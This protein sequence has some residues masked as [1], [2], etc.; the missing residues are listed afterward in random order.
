MC[1]FLKLWRNTV[2]R[3]FK[4]PWLNGQVPGHLTQWFLTPKPYHRLCKRNLPCGWRFFCKFN[5]RKLGIVNNHWLIPV[6]YMVLVS[7][8][9]HHFEND[10]HWPSKQSTTWQS[11]ND[12]FDLIDNFSPSYS[13]IQSWYWSWRE[14]MTNIIMR[15]DVKTASTKVD[16]TL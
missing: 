1:I 13:F 8:V 16:R 12:H 7:M 15:N 14:R 4:K 6:I 10:Y 3:S 5:F 11:C 2:S 9:H